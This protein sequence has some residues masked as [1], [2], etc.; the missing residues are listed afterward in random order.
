MALKVKYSC[1]SS[2]TSFS[3]TTVDFP[4]H[5]MCFL[6]LLEVIF[7]FKSFVTLSAN[8]VCVGERYTVCKL[9]GAQNQTLAV[10]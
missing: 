9:A 1:I 4:L 7:P 6:M 2:P 10:L 3:W 8:K 5:R